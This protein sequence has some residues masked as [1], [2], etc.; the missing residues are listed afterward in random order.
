[1]SPLEPQDVRDCYPKDK[2]QD[3]GFSVVLYFAF[4]ECHESRA[5]AV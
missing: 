4:A 1:M 2:N 5:L 3:V